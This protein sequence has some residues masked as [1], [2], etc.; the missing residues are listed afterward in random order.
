MLKA[1]A[2]AI[3]ALQLDTPRTVAT[4]HHSSSPPTRGQQRR[5]QLTSDLSAAHS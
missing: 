5:V 4:P 3:A 1:A 2:T